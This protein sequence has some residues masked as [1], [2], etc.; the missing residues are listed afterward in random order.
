MAW[1]ELKRMRGKLGSRQEMFLDEMREMDIPSYVVRG[2]RNEIHE[3][4]VEV[5]LYNNDAVAT[6]DVFGTME[7]LW[8]ER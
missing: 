5:R 1:I 3:W 8:L 7:K 6:D 2:G 4:H